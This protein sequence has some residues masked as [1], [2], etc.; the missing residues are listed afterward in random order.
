MSV[1]DEVTK[2]II[3]DD[4]K[5]LPKRLTPKDIY[6]YY[7]KDNHIMGWHTVY[8]IARKLGHRFKEGGRIYVNKTDFIK[9]IYEGEEIEQAI[10]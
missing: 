6:N 5:D 3:L 8:S 7:N 10:S 1:V 9:F 4:I 2:R